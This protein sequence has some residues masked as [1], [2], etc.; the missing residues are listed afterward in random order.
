MGITRRRREGILLNC[1]D[2]LDSKG[3]GHVV[4]FSLLFLRPKMKNDEE[5]H[6]KIDLRP[7]C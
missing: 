2:P 4:S 1:L 3:K 7:L 5:V 6:K